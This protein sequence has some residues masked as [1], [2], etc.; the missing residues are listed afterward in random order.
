MNEQ[1]SSQDGSLLLWD[2]DQVAQVR[3]HHFEPDWWRQRDELAGTAA[4]RGAVWFVEASDG[5]WAIRHY[6]RGGW[7]SNFSENRYLWLGQARSRAFAEWRLLAEMDQLKLPVPAPV[8]ARVTR[9]G[10][11]YTCDL[12][13]RRIA[14]DSLA[15]HLARA[16]LPARR[17]QVL[18]QVLARFH[19]AGV[20]HR[21]LNA[22]NVLIDDNGRVWLI[23]F[24]RCRRRPPGAWRRRN[25]R[26]LRRSLDKVA[27]THPA[28]HFAEADWGALE[29]GYLRGP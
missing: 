9:R 5:A 13:T 18:G 12:I 20:D 15:Q 17:W 28:F 16:P 27:G 8:A 11:C 26:R 7:A 3:S 25:L 21:D 1:Q 2:A 29:G 24:D 19:G 4:G 14:G 22:H 23:D 10:G 6:R